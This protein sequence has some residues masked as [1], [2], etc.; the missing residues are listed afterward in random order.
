MDYTDEELA[1]LA[2]MRTLRLRLRA[3]AQAKVAECEAFEQARTTLI[4]PAGLDMDSRPHRGVPTGA[5]TRA[6]GHAPDAGPDGS[7]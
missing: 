5:G 2:E 7:A 4:H 3:C 6:R 1:D